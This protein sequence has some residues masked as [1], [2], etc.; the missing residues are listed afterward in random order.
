MPAVRNDAAAVE[1]EG[2]T[3]VS[4]ESNDRATDGAVGNPAPTQ[5]D[6]QVE[7]ECAWWVSARLCWCVPWSAAACTSAASWCCSASGCP[8]PVAN[9]TSSSACAAAHCIA[10]AAND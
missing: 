10:I 6:T 7:H 8:A 4:A 1:E 5:H 2:K 3:A 9:S